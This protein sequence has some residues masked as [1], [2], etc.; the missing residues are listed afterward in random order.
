MQKIPLIDLSQPDQI[1]ALAIKQACEDHGFFCIANHGVSI[2]LQKNLDRLSR[3]FFELPLEEKNKIHMK[4]GGTAWRGFFAVGEELTSGKPD[5]KEGLYLG[6]HLGATDA[7]VQSNWPL[8]GKNM[9]PDIAGFQ[10]IIEQYISEMTLLAQRLIQ[11]IS[12]SLGLEA[13]YIYRHYTQSPTLLFRIFHYPPS[14]DASDTWG[15]GEHTDYGLL[16]ILQQDDCGG[17]EVKSKSG[18]IQ[19][20]PKE[21]VFV[22]NIG[23]MLEL[24]TKG[25]Y[26]STPHRVKNTSGRERFSFPFFFDPGFESKIEPLPLLTS[27]ESSQ[28]QRWDDANL[29]RFRGTYRDYL[30]AKVSKVF[31]ELAGEHLKSGGP[32]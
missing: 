26:V 12:L 23:D 29:H 22:C 20:E 9:Y 5:L 18:W 27:S 30:L 1:N 6:E 7:R 16:T 11:L 15:V 28:T 25:T 8:H 3:Q 14:S 24:L 17:L 21:N 4:F 10:N 2:E 19:V 32:N 31:P 13:D